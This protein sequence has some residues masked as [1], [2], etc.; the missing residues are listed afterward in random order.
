MTYNFL[1]RAIGSHGN[2]VTKRQGEE[3]EGWK[4]TVTYQLTEDVRNKIGKE[5]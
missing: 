1:K 5:R 3:G 4:N 2:Q